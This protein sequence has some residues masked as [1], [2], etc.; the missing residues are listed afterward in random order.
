[1]TLTFD[2]GKFVI[3]LRP[4]QHLTSPH[5]TEHELGTYSTSKIKEALRFRNVADAKAE[6]IFLKRMLLQTPLPLGGLVTPHGREL[7]PFQRDRGV[8]FILSQNKTYL[9]HQPGL[10]KSAQAIAAVNTKPGPATIFCPSFLKVTW[11][12]EITKWF[13]RDFPTIAI[14]PETPA[15]AD[16]NWF[17]DFVICSD[18]MI[19]RPWVRAGLQ[20]RKDRY[21]FIDEGHR[22]KSPETGRSIALF[23][24]RGAN[25]ESPGLVYDTEHVSVLSGTPMLARPIELWPVLY[26]LAPETIDFMKFQDF[27]FA[28]CGPR[29]T[30][31]GNYLFLGSSR[32]PE[33]K[34]RIAPFM[35]RIRKEDVLPDLPKKIREVIYL[36]EDPRKPGAIEF[37]RKML[38][39]AQALADPPEELG[40]FAV[41]HHQN[42]LA[43]VGWAA[44]YISAILNEDASESVLVFA[45]HRDVV[46]RLA[47]ALEIQKPMVINGGVPFEDRTKI[48]DAFQS[49]A[50]RLTVGN[51]SAMNLGL[52]LTRATRVIFVEYSW[53]PTENEQAEDRANRIGSKWAVF[54]QY[55]VLPGSLDEYMLEKNFEKQE[56]IERI[57]G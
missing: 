20:K 48:Q 15:Q 35:Q 43:K 17:A 3:R 21:R 33:L 9:A 13:R 41:A 47:K 29:Q 55:L 53:S 25:I 56:R 24:G 36:D 22:Y 37:D 46:D 49:G 40:D 54:A 7:L 42:G 10:G 30:E 19:L 23:G 50:R 2:N 32:E 16:M 18:S 52:T 45:H 6:K 31:R 12:R 34:A 1:M 28:Y 26:A 51:L 38:R 39:K 57:I 5:W 4:N 44:R 14:V 8:P 27:G 11:A